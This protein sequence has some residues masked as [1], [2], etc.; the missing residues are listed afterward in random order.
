MRDPKGI[1][2]TL[3]PEQNRIYEKIAKDFWDTIPLSPKCDLCGTT[4]IKKKCI[5]KKCRRYR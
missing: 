2:Y 1:S 4:L 5:N 3:N